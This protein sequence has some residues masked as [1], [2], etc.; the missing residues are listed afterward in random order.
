M[1]EVKAYVVI[2]LLYEL[3]RSADMAKSVRG[4]CEDMLDVRYGHSAC[5]A[6]P[7]A[8]ERVTRAT[9]PALT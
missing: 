8:S 3:G 7:S 5:G 9:I 2:G 1:A 6:L 4:R